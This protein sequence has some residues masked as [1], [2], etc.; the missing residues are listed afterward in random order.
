MRE[1]LLRQTQNAAHHIS[2][3]LPLGDGAVNNRR[4]TQ[5]G[6]QDRGTL[7]AATHRQLGR[8][9]DC[10]PV[11]SICGFLGVASDALSAGVGERS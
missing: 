7:V 9:S 5:D 10:W 6:I 2:A 1:A 8:M 4:G 11:M 3:Q